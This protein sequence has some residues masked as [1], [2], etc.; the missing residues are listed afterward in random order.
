MIVEAAAVRLVE[1]LGDGR[2][3]YEMVEGEHAGA[4][5]VGPRHLPELRPGPGAG[6][7][8]RLRREYWQL[9]RRARREADRRA[10]D[11]L[12]SFLDDDQRRHRRTTGH[13]WVDT[14]L[15]WLRLGRMYDLRL[16]PTDHPNQEMAMCVVPAGW[17]TRRHSTPPGDF[18]VNVL[19]AAVHQP[20]EFVRV[21]VVQWDLL[22]LAPSGRP[23]DACGAS[24]PFVVRHHRWLCA[25]CGIAP[26][27]R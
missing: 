17:S 12:E 2:C 3:L 16:R 23:C 4:L 25:R 13:F 27:S 1:D 19:L 15:G 18:W 11:L 8:P 26:A 22:P 9:D 7:R 21:A 6:G 24:A 20:E 10:E 5:V 14:A